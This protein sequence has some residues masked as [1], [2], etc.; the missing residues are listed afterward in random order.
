MKRKLIY[1]GLL[2]AW[3]CVIFAF[4]AQVGDDSQGMSN[5]IIIFLKKLFHIGVEEHSLL[6]D[7]FSFIVR[8]AAH[9]SEYAIL[10]ILSWLFIKEKGWSHPSFF[11]L[12]WSVIYAC[13]DE[14]HQLF[15]SGRSGQL[16]D[17]GIDAIG[18]LIGLLLLWILRFFIYKLQDVKRQKR[19]EAGSLW[20]YKK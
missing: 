13:S 12:L 7:S 17:V 5:E 9:M 19:K 15:V 20:N 1:G 10:A 8:K 14:F 18:A 4:S 11:A 6:W 16:K 2:I 3:M